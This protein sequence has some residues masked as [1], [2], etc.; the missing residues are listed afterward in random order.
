MLAQSS[1]VFNG[2]FSTFW[3][4]LQTSIPSIFVICRKFLL[5]VVLYNNETFI[6]KAEVQFEFPKIID[7]HVSLVYWSIEIA[8]EA[9]QSV[10]PGHG[11]E[12]TTISRTGLSRCTAL[13][14]CIF[15]I[16]ATRKKWNFYVFVLTFG[17]LI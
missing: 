15:T 7:T 12:I 5:V 11:L 9:H 4:R 2:D 1:K 17:L 3:M 8:M 6:C 13:N 16:L 10:V 14:F